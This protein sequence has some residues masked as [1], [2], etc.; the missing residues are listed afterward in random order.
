MVNRLQ[1]VRDLA[2]YGLDLAKSMGAEVINFEEV[3]VR[4]AL[5]EMTGGIGPDAC[6]DAV[7]MESHGFSGQ[8]HGQGE[9]GGQTGNR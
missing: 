9:G 5:V 8:R 2:D 7:G 3:D 1:L 6:I 4:E